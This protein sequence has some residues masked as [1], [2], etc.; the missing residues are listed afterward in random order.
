MDHIETLRELIKRG[1]ELM[2]Q[3]G[4]AVI[5]GYNG[6]LQPD[7]VSWRLQAISAIEE[8]GRSGKPLLREIDSDKEGSFF[9]ESSAARVL[10]VLK[11]ALAIAQ[12]DGRITGPRIEP[13]PAMKT[14]L[15]ST[16]GATAGD[17]FVV[18]GHDTALLN[19]VTR[20]L[21]KLE[22]KAVVLFE[23][24]GRGQ[25]VIEK[26]ETSSNVAFA[27]V[28]LTPDDVGR[29]VKDK[30]L[31]PRARQN[32]VLELGFFIG[33]LGRSQVAVMYD[34]SVELPSDYRGV[35]YIKVDAEGAWKLR[36]ARE[37]KQASIPIDMNKA[38]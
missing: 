14:P 25:T 13:S 19:Q 7:Y 36:L 38:I 16:G 8:L 22:L 11:A 23:Q 26:L 24:A 18:H 31:R 21:E 10:G 9:Y 28:L 2:P 1:E 6:A 35:E 37:L 32:V 27:V 3:G 5:E 20:F 15:G 17:V 33:K 4:D 34:E 29:A 30:P 12:R